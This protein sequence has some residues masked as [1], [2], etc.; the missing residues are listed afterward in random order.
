MFDEKAYPSEVLANHEDLTNVNRDVFGYHHL[1][2]QEKIQYTFKFDNGYTISVI[3]G[4]GAHG[5]QDAPYELGLMYKDLGMTPMDGITDSP[6]PISDCN[7][8]DEILA[9]IEIVKGL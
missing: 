8:E 9:K 6:E 1:G 7:T 2:E 5:F 4:F 3:T